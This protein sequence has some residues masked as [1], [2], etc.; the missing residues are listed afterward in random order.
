[1]S[2][3]RGGTDVARSVAEAEPEVDGCRRSTSRTSRRSSRLVVAM[4]VVICTS[5]C[6]SS[7]VPGLN[8]RAAPSTASRI[9]G[10]LT[11]AGTSV[12]IVCYTRGQPIHGQTLWYRISQ[13]RKGYVTAYYVRADSSTRANTPSC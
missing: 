8:V 11:T 3:R 1:V 10:R 5:A 9:V 7:T 12:N 13:P 2:E 6:E 4:L